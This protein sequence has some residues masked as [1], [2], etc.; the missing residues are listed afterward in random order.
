MFFSVSSFVLT[1]IILCQLLDPKF[2][3]LFAILMVM[4]KM[5]LEGLEVAKEHHGYGNIGGR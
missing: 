3:L 1:N 5:L 2:S 4:H